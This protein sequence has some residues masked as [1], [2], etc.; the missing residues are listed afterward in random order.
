MT[1]PASEAGT[2]G[3]AVFTIARAVAC[4]G[5]TDSS[6]VPKAADTTAAVPLTGSRVLPGSG[7]P[8][9]RPSARRSSDDLRHLGRAGPVGGG[10]LGRVR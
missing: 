5:C 7:V 10:V 9:V 4:G 1:T 6:G 8:T 3:V 2:W